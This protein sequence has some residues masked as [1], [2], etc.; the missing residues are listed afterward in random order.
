MLGQDIVNEINRKLNGEFEVV[1]Y[2][3]DDWNTI[4]SALNENIDLY[5][6]S[7][8]WRTSYN[9][10]YNLGTI[11]S[12]EFYTIK[13]SDI[14]AIDGSNRAHV[15]FY[16]PDGVIVDKYKL[17]AQDMFDQ[18]HNDDKVVTINMNGLQIKPK[19]TTDKI[20]GCDIIL[21]IYRNVKTVSKVTDL[22]TTD[23]TYWLIIKTASDLAATSPVAFI[24][25]NFDIFDVQATKRM[26]DMKKANRITQSSTPAIGQWTPSTRPDGR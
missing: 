18:S 12:S 23:D 24:A 14:A 11:D 25:R 10:M 2:Q 3:S 5:N 22:V 8:N 16:N 4:I 20:Y 19:V 1:I 7:A 26:K 9:P 6:K 21:P 17:V 15:L 13:F